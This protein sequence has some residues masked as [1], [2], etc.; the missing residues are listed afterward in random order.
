MAAPARAAD[1]EPVAGPLYHDRDGELHQTTYRPLSGH[2][3]EGDR[4]W[5]FS[6]VF[7]P[8]HLST[9]IWHRW[10][11]YD[12]A[13]HTWLESDRIPFEIVGGRDGGYRGYNRKKN[14]SEGLWRVLVETEDGREVGRAGFVVEVSPT[15]RGTTEG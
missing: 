6:A 3:R 5:C 7:A 11:R 13:D 4:A 2:L 9:R 14:L 15:G 10:Q 12:E 8:R 1:G